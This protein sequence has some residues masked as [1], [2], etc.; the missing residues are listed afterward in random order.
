MRIIKFAVNNFRTISGGLENNLINFEGSNT[1]FIFGQNNVGKSTFLKAYEFFYK[2]DKPAVDDVF[3]KDVTKLIEFELELGIDDIDLKYIEENQP[4]KINSF[5]SYLTSRSTIKMRKIFSFT[6]DKKPKFDKK[7]DKTWNPSTNSWDDK[8]FGTIGLSGVFQALMPTPILIKAMPTEAEVEGVVNEILAAKAKLRLDDNQ[9]KELADAQQTVKA[10][11]DK[12]YNPSTIDRYKEHVND[13]FQQLFPDI[14]I[15]LLDSD[16]VKWTED[17]FGK[18]FNV[19]FKKKKE[20]GTYDENT[21]SSYSAIGHGTVRTAIFSLMLMRDVAHELKKSNNRKEFLILFEEP[22][23]FLYPKILK[24]LRELVY[25]VSDLDYPFQVLCASHSPQ[26]IDLSKRQSTLVRMSKNKNGTQLYQIK[27]EDLQ[28]ASETSDITKLKQKMYEVLRFNPYL[29]ES[30]YADE[31]LLVE[32]PTEEIIVRGILQ[33]AN[34]PKD[35]FVVNCGSV[36]N[37]PF[38]QKVYRKFA[39]KNHVIC[40]SD[41]Q[42]IGDKD[43]FGNPTFNNGIQKSIYNEHLLNCQNKPKVGGLLRVHKETFE[44]AHSSESV[45]TELQYPEYKDSDG[46]PFNA[47]KYWTEI[48]EPNFNH[49]EI[50]TVPI[51]FFIEEILGFD[52]SEPSTAVPVTD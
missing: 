1:I 2:D 7:I 19:E 22:E 27:D 12:M 25:A 48:L 3:Q 10:L 13:H 43:A 15:D 11:Q 23:L 32:G 46:K 39:I 31:V 21:P 42:T 16:K 41:T 38:Y 14:S 8:G 49:K 50:T 9:L 45:N 52:W 4:K 20:D 26:M 51:I 17:K 30:F 37:I 6:Q 18:K 34:H 29:C 36:T 33:K 40:D 24:K 44:P 28:E 47:N 35:L 5:K